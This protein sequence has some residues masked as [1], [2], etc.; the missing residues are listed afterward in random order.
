M[1]LIYFVCMH[2]MYAGV[3]GCQKMVLDPLEL[4]LGEAVNHYEDAGSQT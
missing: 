1:F 2:H 4:E 3:L